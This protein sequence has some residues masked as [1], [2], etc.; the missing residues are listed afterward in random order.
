[1]ISSVKSKTPCGVRRKSLI[2]LK[3]QKA[4]IVLQ[5]RH[6]IILHDGSEKFVSHKHYKEGKQTHLA[7]FRLKKKRGKVNKLDLIRGNRNNT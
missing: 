1:V 3:P 5:F 4:M 2:L 7:K 6:F